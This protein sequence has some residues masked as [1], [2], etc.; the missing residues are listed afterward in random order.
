MSWRERINKIYRGLRKKFD[1]DSINPIVVSQN[2][3]KS[4]DLGVTAGEADEWL[5]QTAVYSD[6]PDL[7]L[8]DKVNCASEPLN[9]ADR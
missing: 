3:Q 6:L 9:K 5:D 1:K 2:Q 4:G 8:I 7:E